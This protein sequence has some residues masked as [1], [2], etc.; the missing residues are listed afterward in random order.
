MKLH[1]DLDEIIEPNG[2]DWTV[3]LIES[4]RGVTIRTTL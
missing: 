4:I 3:S 2:G 1:Y